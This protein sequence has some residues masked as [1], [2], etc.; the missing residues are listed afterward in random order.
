MAIFAIAER[1]LDQW[2]GDPASTDIRGRL[3][4][5]CLDAG[6]QYLFGSTLNGVERTAIIALA[7]AILHKTRDR[8][9]F[10]LWPFDRAEARLTATLERAKAIMDEMLA[11]PRR[12]SRDNGQLGDMVGRHQGEQGDWLRDEFAAMIL[13]G[14][15]P[16]ADALAWTL[17]LL[18]RH[19]GTLERVVAEID[20]A[21]STRDIGSTAGLTGLA[22]TN[23]AVKEALRLFPPAWMTGRIVARDTHL[24]GFDLPEGTALMVSPWVNHRDSRHFDAPDHFQ[25]DR[26]LDS[27]LEQ[28]LPR[29]AFF[30]FGGGS[31][32]CIGEHFTMIHMVAI[33]VCLLSRYALREVQG[34]DVRPFPALVLRPLGIRII[35]TPRR[36]MGRQ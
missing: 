24:G 15:E 18:A 1:H 22:E 20:A 25:T 19:P 33:L 13:S 10:R 34:A 30:P 29:Y 11:R 2:L 35:L 12:S 8:N 31:R 7:D 16:M 4:P 5:L 32:R 3:Q 27:A 36:P 17:H 23:A 9:R 6:C 26:W 28:R 21:R 14:L